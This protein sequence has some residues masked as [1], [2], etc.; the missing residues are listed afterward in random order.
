VRDDVWCG[1][2]LASRRVPIAGL[3]S[4]PDQ[5]GMTPV[6]RHVTMTAWRLLSP[7]QS[8]R[9]DR[10][11]TDGPHRSAPHQRGRRDAR[12][13]ATAEPCR[14]SE[15]GAVGEVRQGRVSVDV[16]AVGCASPSAGADGVHGP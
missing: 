8:L 15:R 3:T 9:H 11:G 7:N 13:L 1:I 14:V 5:R 10:D 6:A 2:P 12:G 16:E 4:P